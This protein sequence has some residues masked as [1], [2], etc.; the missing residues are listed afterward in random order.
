MATKCN[1]VDKE[2]RHVLLSLFFLA[3]GLFV[4]WIANSHLGIKGDAV[5]VSVLV[6]PVL[7]YLI[8]SGR[9]KE[10]KGPGGLEAKF[11][12]TATETVNPAYESVEP[13]T[14]EMQ[15]AAKEG[16]RALQ[17][18]KQDLDESRPIAMTMVLGKQGYYSRDAVLA[19]IES[20][21]QYRNFKFV[22]FLDDKSRFVAYMPFWAVR[23]LLQTAGGEDFIST[24]N[25]GR[26]MDL[27]K[28]P[29]IIKDPIFVDET[30]AQA[31]KK[32]M[33]QNLEALVVVDKNKAL[34]GIVERDYILSA[35]ILS[36]T[37]SKSAR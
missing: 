12:E 2:I 24:I 5:F 17:K 27:F 18:R 1:E 6:L 7:I 10:F 31:L 9:L 8:V 4:I 35:M 16:F 14:E 33:D 32:M 22:V 26:L 20:L 37:P 25:E 30:N 21:S 36:L 23:S 34:K 29:G 13:S 19:Y 28:V 15:V 3:P 11:A